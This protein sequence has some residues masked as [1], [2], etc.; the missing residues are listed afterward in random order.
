M[1]IFNP[2]KVIKTKRNQIEK[3]CPQSLCFSAVQGF[4]ICPYF[5]IYNGG[6]CPY[7]DTYEV[8]NHDRIKKG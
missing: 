4:F 8:K 3:K 6:I 1:L 2:K 7:F 5:G